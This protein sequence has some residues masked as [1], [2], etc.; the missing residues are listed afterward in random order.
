M[1][2][3]SYKEQFLLTQ[4]QQHH[5]KRTSKSRAPTREESLMSIAD[6]IRPSDPK[7]EIESPD[8]LRVATRRGG[9]Y[10]VSWDDDLLIDDN[11][12]IKPSGLFMDRSSWIWRR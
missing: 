3:Q 11:P 12:P 8:T 5:Q 2:A 6:A 9:G 10:A 4:Q 1:P 7:Y